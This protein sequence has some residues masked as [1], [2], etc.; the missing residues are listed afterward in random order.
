MKMNQKITLMIALLFLTLLN[1]FGQETMPKE[2]E[3]EIKTSGRYYFGE[4]TAFDEA[5]AKKIALDELIQAVAVALVQQSIKADKPE[6]L[7]KSLEMQA[8]IA[9]LPLTGR[10]RMIAWIEKEKVHKVEPTPTPTP[11]TPTPPT[12]PMP[13]PTPPTP[14]PTSP[15]P[16]PTP[17]SPPTTIVNPVVQ[18]LATSDTYSQLTRKI[19]S[20]R[21][22]GK[23]IIYGRKSSF[24][25]PDRCYIAVFNA[26]KKMIA[27]LE[28]GNLSRTDLLT[29]NTIQ[30]PEH[31]FS[32]NELT[33][34]QIR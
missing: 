29:G 5:E 17:P 20:W 34:I 6:D 1:G 32:G 16:E 14:P 33:W 2:Q 9:Q 13:P 10:V 15:D 25:Y 22:K 18:D 24:Q 23:E 12:P 7:Q 27:F 28:T 19:S 4:G 31:H 11:P 30:N 3:R 21:G 8:S 26:S